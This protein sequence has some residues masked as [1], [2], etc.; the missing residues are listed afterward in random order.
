MAT[1]ANSTIN[2]QPADRLIQLVWQHWDEE[3]D[4]ARVLDPATGKWTSARD[5]HLANT[6][7]EIFD[8]FIQDGQSK[9]YASA[10]IEFMR[11]PCTQEGDWTLVKG[12]MPITEYMDQLAG[13]G[14]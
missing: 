10:M 14:V 13:M 12:G 8:L 7:R 6:E 5:R 1:N 2:Q 9:E 3:G 4:D 11:R